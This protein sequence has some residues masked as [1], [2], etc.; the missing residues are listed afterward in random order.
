MQRPSDEALITFLDGELDGEA[1]DAVAAA[2]ERDA[3]SRARADALRE[4][5]GALRAA[6]DEVLREEVPQRLLDAAR[7]VRAGTGETAGGVVDLVAARARRLGRASL[8]RRWDDRRWWLKSAVAA[9]LLCLLVGAGGGYLAGNGPADNNPPATHAALGSQWLDNIAGYHRLLINAGINESGLVDVPPNGTRPRASIPK[10]PA[11]FRLPNL[12]PLGLAFEGA[13]FLIIEGRPA[14]QLFYTSHDK[15]LGSITIV[16]GT[17]G[18]P[19]VVPSAQRRDEMNFI[20]WRHKGHAYAL[21][22][23]ANVSYLW[24]I[25]KDIVFQL[26][27]AA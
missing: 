15:K 5:A 11:G 13:R 2:V 4:S 17:S 27:A 21:V 9:S 12:K 20:Y 14:T 26:D 18:K 10:L 8:P 19:D 1:R 16:V 24:T 23:T 6:M 7:G 25:A 3:P 22:G